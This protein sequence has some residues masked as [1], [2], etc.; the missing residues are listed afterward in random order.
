M[1]PFPRIDAHVHLPA[2]S[3]A[4]R[5]VV[6][7]AQLKVINICVDSAEL[8]GLAAQ[9]GWYSELRRRQP[10]R[11]AWVTSFSLEGFGAAGWA[12]RVIAQLAEDFDTGGAVGCKVWKN[13]GMDLRDPATGEFVFID[14]ARFEPIFQ[15]LQEQGRPVLMHI[16]EP[17]ACW[18]PL[19][20][21]NPHYG[22]YSANPQ[23]HWCG[24]TDVPTH[25]RLIASRD[26][27][28][29][30][31]PRLK[32][33]GAHYGS[34]E[35]DVS[36]VAARFERYPN[37]HVDTSARL[38]DVGLQ[39]ARDHDKVRSFFIQYADRVLWGTDPVVT[40]PM[41]QLPPDQ[42]QPLLQ[43]LPRMWQK[44]WRFFATSDE[45]HFN[46]VPARGL[47]LPDDVLRKL[48]VDNARRV[49]AGA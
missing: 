8:G 2:D 37:F 40:R 5:D 41:S 36:E 45:L 3:D 17:L 7:Q 11:F 12:E 22:Y 25:A 4:A 30:R 31:F 21:A 35:F 39:A 28:A 15:W 13:V 14:D 27:I 24:R 43:W 49:Y 44:E 10:E 23:W 20:P 26:A 46:N 48:F 18:S 47:A 19:D 32:V 1:N 9:R 16:G 34:L 38:A 6:A 29:E 42:L 33:V